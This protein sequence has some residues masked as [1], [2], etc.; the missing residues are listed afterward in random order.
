MEVLPLDQ[1]VCIYGR[2]VRCAACAVFSL[3]VRTNDR[4]GALLTVKVF[5]R[6]RGRRGGG[7]LRCTEVAGQRLAQRPEPAGAGLRKLITLDARDSSGPRLSVPSF[8]LC[9]L[10]STTTTSSMHLAA[11]VTPFGQSVTAVG[12]AVSP[13]IDKSS[14][15]GKQLGPVPP[16]WFDGSNGV[17]R[18]CMPICAQ[19]CLLS[20]RSMHDLQPGDV[21]VAKLVCS[22]ERYV[23][24]DALPSLLVLTERHAWPCLIRVPRQPANDE[25]WLGCSPFANY[26]LMSAPP[27]YA[28]RARERTRASGGEIGPQGLQLLATRSEPV[29]ALRASIRLP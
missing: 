22:W 14:P 4:D 2:G 27:T 15:H 28:R 20:T 23:C 18:I 25:G 21:G 9:S 11:P 17:T 5:D 1:V 26:V 19:N 3:H 13:T 6:H 12:F 8:M 10:L 29:W 24:K 16:R 7:V